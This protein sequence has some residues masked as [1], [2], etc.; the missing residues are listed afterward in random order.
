MDIDAVRSL[1]RTVIEQAPAFDGRD[2]LLGQV[3]TI[4]VVSG[5]LTMLTLSVDRSLPSGRP[6]RGPVPGNCWARASEGRPIGT[7]LVWADDGYIDTLECGWVTD[8]PPTEVPS[9]ANLATE[10]CDGAE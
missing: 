6:L 8:D 2:E 1:V 7:M 5:P 3:P 9:P 4:E 10:Q